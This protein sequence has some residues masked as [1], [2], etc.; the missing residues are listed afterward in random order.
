MPWQKNR[1][2]SIRDLGTYNLCPQTL[3]LVVPWKCFTIYSNWIV[4]VLFSGCM[5]SW[6]VQAR[7]NQSLNLKK[8]SWLHQS[9]I[10]RC[11]WFLFTDTISCFITLLM[12]VLIF[13]SYLAPKKAFFSCL[14]CII[15]FSTHFVQEKFDCQGLFHS[16]KP[17]SEG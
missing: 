1:N 2:T 15:V 4:Y 6:L 8:I 7:E 16:F 17:E 14:F 12:T 3:F 9:W 10:K 5:A 13:I 11:K